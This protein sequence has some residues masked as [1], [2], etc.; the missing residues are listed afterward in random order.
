MSEFEQKIWDD[1]WEVANSKAKQ[2]EL[3]IRAIHG[4]ALSIKAMKGNT[5][6]IDLR[7]SGG[8]SLKPASDVVTPVRPPA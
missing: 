6:Y 2:D 7:A 4:E 5:Y 8:L 1:F 3:G